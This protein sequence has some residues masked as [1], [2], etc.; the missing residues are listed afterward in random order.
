MRRLAAHLTLLAAL[1]LAAVLAAAPQTSAMSQ[2]TVNVPVTVGAESSID[3]NGCMNID[4]GV[5]L[6]GAVTQSNTCTIGFGTSNSGAGVQLVATDSSDVW[7]LDSG[8]DQIPD[9]SPA[10]STLGADSV[11]AALTSAGAGTTADQPLD[12]TPLTSDP[13]WFGMSSS[14]S[15]AIAHT[16]TVGWGQ[17]TLVFG[18]RPLTSQPPGLYSNT[19]TF[20][21]VVL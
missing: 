14:T 19:V 5:A 3:T 9:A 13:V 21:V 7:G 15:R 12:P 4:F 20:T 1:V 11:G 16:S 17:A 2:G 10:P 6:R 18:M 8:I